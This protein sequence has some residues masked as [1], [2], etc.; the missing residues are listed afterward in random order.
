MSAGPTE[1]SGTNEM[2]ASPATTADD[3]ELYH[4]G[5]IELVY[6]DESPINISGVLRHIS[7][8]RRRHRIQHLHFLGC[9]FVDGTRNAFRTIGKKLR[10]T[11]NVHELAINN[12][13][14]VGNEEL[15]SLAPFLNANT[16]LRSL[17]LTGASFNASAI[18]EV[19]P[20]FRRNSSLEVLVLGENQC[21]GDEGVDAILSALQSGR[22]R[23]RLRVLAVEGCGVGIK[24]V[25]SISDFMTTTGVG[26]SLRVLELS[27]NNIGDAGGKILAE[28]IK[29]GHA[30][31]HLGLNNAELS[32]GAA[33]AFGEVLRSNRS[34]HTLSL[35]NN[36]GITNV[37][38]SSL[39]KAIHNTDS[40]K[41][42]IGS[43][44]VLRNL[45][46]RGCNRVHRELLQLA[47]QL[48]AHIRLLSSKD[49]V[50]RLKIS[51]HL[52]NAEG[53]LALEEFDLE[54]MP[55]ILAFVGKSNGMNS[56][57]HTLK[58]LPVLYSQYDH[59]QQAK[60][61]LEEEDIPSKKNSNFLGQFKPSSRRAR[62]HYSVF[63]RSVPRRSSMIRYQDRRIRNRHESRSK[64]PAAS[65]NNSQQYLSSIGGNTATATFVTVLT[66]ALLMWLFHTRDIMSTCILSKLFFQEVTHLLFQPQECG[67]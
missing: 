59:P 38:V 2:K 37:G 45:S 49:E 20:F 65:C 9:Q 66:R 15:T 46:L 5:P 64:V 52:K 50:I 1:L 54:L 42:I 4:P 62:K 8:A 43:N 44:H 6:G 12:V 67:N 7:S 47:T 10:R 21:V 60:K 22:G 26:S 34:L 29:N 28:A 51:T 25:S 27:N 18:N 23:K 55:H 41:D 11:N 61:T 3:D 30:L 63:V 58:S 40:I 32:N 24:G 36:T 14:D 48:S 17:D 39:L 19:K 35:Q 33:I 31:G 13:P 53:G 56:L 16:T 57:F